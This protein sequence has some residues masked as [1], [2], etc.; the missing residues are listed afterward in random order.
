MKRSLFL[1]LFLLAALSCSQQ[2]GRRTDG[3]A[4]PLPKK[5]TAIF[6]WATELCDYHSTY[7]PDRYTKEQLRAT[8]A[9]WLDNWYLEAPAVAATPDELPNLRADALRHDYEQMRTHLQNLTPVNIPFWQQLKQRRLRAMEAEYALKQLAI[10]AYTKP[11]VLRYSR[12]DSAGAAYVNALTTDDT[13]ALLTAWQRLH[14]EQKKNSGLPEQLDE[15]FRKKVKAANHLQLARVEL[16]AYGWW[17]HT[18]PAVSYVEGNDRME[19]AFKA[20]FTTHET[21]CSEP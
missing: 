17:N 9:L 21:T 18:R 16:M 14:E 20:L 11:E 5:D 6:T 12:Y 1:L 13:T 3:A 15:A 4:G 10:S 8:H 7:H 2:T 19:A